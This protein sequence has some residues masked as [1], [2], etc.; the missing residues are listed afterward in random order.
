MVDKHPAQ[1]DA[2]DDVVET[3]SDGD[4][5]RPNFL[6]ESLKLFTLDVANSE[7]M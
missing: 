1:P 4:G 2:K 6:Y 5:R 7:T 3:N